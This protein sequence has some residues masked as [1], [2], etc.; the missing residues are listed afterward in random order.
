MSDLVGTNMYIAPEVISQKGKYNQ[1]SD[2]WSV[3]IVAYTVLLGIFP[4]PF[5][6]NAEFFYLKKEIEAGDFDRS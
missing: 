6:Q 4:F 1:S 5:Q 3:G 2:M